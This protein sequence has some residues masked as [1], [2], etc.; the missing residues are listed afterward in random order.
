MQ[1][2][3][4]RYDN[5]VRILYFSL[6]DKLLEDF[7]LTV[8]EKGWKRINSSKSDAADTE[9]YWDETRIKLH[10]LE[11]RVEKNNNF[12]RFK[13][14]KAFLEKYFGSDR[15]KLIIHNNSGAEDIKK[16]KEL[17]SEICNYLKTKK[18]KYNESYREG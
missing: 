12:K 9:F 18:I 7:L 13:G 4:S 6:G 10:I 15:L 5:Y 8:K 3:Y 16:S 11:N 2:E 17:F 1:R 14:I